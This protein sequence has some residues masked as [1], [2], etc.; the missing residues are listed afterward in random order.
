MK[1]LIIGSKGQLGQTLLTVLANQES[2]LGP[3]PACCK[4]AQVV[5]ADLDV[6]DITD[7]KAVHQFF[8]RECPDVVFNCSAMTN[9]DGCETDAITAM[10]V[11]AMGVSYLAKEAMAMGAK[12]IHVSTDYVFPGDGKDP[13]CEWDRTDPHTVYGKSKRLG[14][15]MALQQC[16]RTF[17]VRT[18]WLYGV[19]GNNF[20]KTMRR[21]GS[22]KEAISVVCD[23]IGNPTN[24]AD[25][26]YHMLLL[27]QTED[28]GIYH[29]TGEGICSW[30][31]FACEI[32]RLSGLPCQV[33]PCTTA[34]Y[35]SKTPRPAYSA[36][37][38]LHLECTVGDHMRPWK[39]ALAE[40]IA[41]LD[42]KG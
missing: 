34:E 10:K 42:Q 33:N 1:F 6:L 40:Y 31:E 14:E 39:T 30:Y 38:N 19:E 11:N 4:D 13:Y 2:A 27:A 41:I 12:F 16:S 17:V 26:A 9:V 21:L 24:A 20:V 32:M 36:L 18:S 15:E 29:C 28:Y 5:G 35:P 22:T 3:L 7:A 37:R 23:Q 8:A 25:L